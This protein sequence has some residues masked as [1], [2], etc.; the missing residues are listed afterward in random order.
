MAH[1]IFSF[2][3]PVGSEHTQQIA[4]VDQADMR[5][6]GTTGLHCVAEL[7]FL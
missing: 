1:F 4:T 6:L 2:L 3:K 5:G 7:A